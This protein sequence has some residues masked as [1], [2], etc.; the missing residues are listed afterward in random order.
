[1]SHL[2]SRAVRRRR[3]VTV[4]ERQVKGIAN[5]SSESPVARERDLSAEEEDP[6]PRPSVLD[7]YTWTRYTCRT[8]GSRG[9]GERIA[10]IIFAAR[11][12]AE[13]ERERYFRITHREAPAV[14]AALV[15]SARNFEEEHTY[16]LRVPTRVD[17]Y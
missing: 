4:H 9:T 15:T 17:Y 1:M 10:G 12:E 16:M 5:R 13:R 8:T 11:R 3:E 2:Y 6:T 14:A 7:P